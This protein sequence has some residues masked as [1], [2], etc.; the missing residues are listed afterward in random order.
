M[1]RKI[2]IHFFWE[3]NLKKYLKFLLLS[4]ILTS[5]NQQVTENQIETAIALTLEANPTSTSTST[6]TIVPTNTAT[7]TITPSLTPTFT[8]QPTLTST[9][10]LRVITADPRDFL[11]VKKDL[12]AEGLYY[13]PNSTWMSI[14]TNQEVISGWTVEEGREYIIE[15]EREVGWYVYFKR[16]TRAVALPDEIHSNVVRYKTAEGAYLAQTKF[17]LSSRDDYNEWKILDRKLDLGDFNEVYLYRERTS[18]GDYLVHYRIYF[19]YRNFGV[20]VDGY[21]YE[22]DVQYEFVDSLAQIILDK[23]QSAELSNPD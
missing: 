14:H 10:D 22:I 18:G 19:N 9:P 8:P 23:L 3:E 6:I 11:F 2:L 1:I 20:T 5:C 4:I 12:P 15:T 16:G 13:I 17:S 7:V 21:G